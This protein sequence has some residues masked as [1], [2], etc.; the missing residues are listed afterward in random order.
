MVIDIDVPPFGITVPPP[1]GQSFFHGNTLVNRN[2]M[3][4]HR[5][6]G[7]RGPILLS[8]SAWQM[9]HDVGSIKTWAEFQRKRWI[10]QPFVVY[11]DV[12]KAVRTFAGN[13]FGV[14]YLADVMNPLVAN[15]L[16]WHEPGKHALVLRGIHRTE[17]I[18]C[19]GATG[20]WK[21]YRCAT[22]NRLSAGDWTP[23]VH[24]PCKECWKRSSKERG[25]IRVQIDDARMP[26]DVV[27]QKLIDLRMD[28]GWQGNPN[29]ADKGAG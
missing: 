11:R 28:Y 21:V 6:R 29:N 12:E 15:G 23:G 16:P 18:P 19:S 13:A 17:L 8:Q 9:E 5:V 7:Y 20:F 25:K 1:W 4:L 24:H 2:W 22:C 27:K 14:A 26:E 10:S 3:I